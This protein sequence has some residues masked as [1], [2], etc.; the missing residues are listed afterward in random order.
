MGKYLGKVEEEVFGAVDAQLQS[1]SHDFLV[2]GGDEVLAVGVAI[3]GELL[4]CIIN[5]GALLV[6][7]K[8]LLQLVGEHLPVPALPHSLLDVKLPV[9]LSPFVLFTLHHF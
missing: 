3:V 1:Q 2:G 9:H 5:E 6:L 4:V 7:I 8:Q